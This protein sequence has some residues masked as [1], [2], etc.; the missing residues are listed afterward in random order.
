MAALAHPVNLS[1]DKWDSAGAA[2]PSLTPPHPARNSASKS[3][4]ADYWPAGWLIY[5]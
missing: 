1:Q 4:T 5:S 3:A 2:V